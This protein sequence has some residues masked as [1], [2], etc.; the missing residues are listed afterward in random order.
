VIADVDVDV[1]KDG[2]VDLRATFAADGDE[3]M[4]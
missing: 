2:A 4:R 3:P 1:V